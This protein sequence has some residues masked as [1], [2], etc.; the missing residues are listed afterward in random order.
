MF[1]GKAMPTAMSQLRR[2]VRQSVHCDVNGLAS[3]SVK[4]VNAS[5]I[6]AS[7]G[8][9]H[10]TLEKLTLFFVLLVHVNHT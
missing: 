9:L 1:L 4:R 5:A 6:S 8:F 3:G 10:L 7:L 2:G